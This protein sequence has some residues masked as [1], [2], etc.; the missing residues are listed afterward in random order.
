MEGVMGLTVR[1]GNQHCSWQKKPTIFQKLFIFK[2]GEQE[3]VSDTPPLTYH[4][5]PTA[6]FLYEKRDDE[7]TT[8]ILVSTSK[9]Y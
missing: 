6:Y 8:H 5:H 7:G 3:D 2:R 4:P 9:S 1:E